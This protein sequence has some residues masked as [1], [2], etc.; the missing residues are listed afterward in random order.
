M[1]CPLINA[2]TMKAKHLFL[3]NIRPFIEAE[4]AFL[5]ASHEKPPVVLIT[6]ENGTGKS[7]VPDAIRGVFGPEYGALERNIAGRK[8]SGES[9]IQL[10]LEKDGEELK[11]E[12]S[13][14]EGNQIKLQMTDSQVKRVANAPGD[15]QRGGECPNWVADFWPSASASGS[16]KITSLAH[17]QHQYFL[18]NAFKGTKSKESITQLICHFDYVRDSRDPQEKATGERLYEILENIIK[19]SLLD[20]GRLSHV[21]RSN[22]E[23]VIIQN[24]QPVSL[25]NL[26]SGNTYLIQNMVGL[27]GKMYAVHFLRK[28][29]LTELCQTPGILLIDEAENQLH[30]KWQKRFISSVLD[31]FPNLQI[32][33]ITHSPFIISSVSNARLFVCQARTDHCIIMDETA[34]YSNK[35][36][37]EILMSP[38]FEETQPFNHEI[39]QLIAAWEKA[40]SADDETTRERIETELKKINPDYFSYFE[41]DKLLEELNGGKAKT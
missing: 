31:I 38:L 36:A 20:G 23:P 11:L 3:R 16:Y 32:I 18:N 19:S 13:E 26:S 1:I 5:N 6:G 4:M 12:S 33:A 40:V 30:P 21:S 41:M 8:C 7:I 34:E 2:Q 35:P 15:V 29:P 17:P 27:L 14:I 37:D 28:T 24:N 39:S 10:I 25:E 22:Y 9:D